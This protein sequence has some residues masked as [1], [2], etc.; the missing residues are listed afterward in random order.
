[1]AS[2]SG[3]PTPAGP[4][5]RWLVR[6]G[7]LLLTALQVYL[8][9]RLRPLLMRLCAELPFGG[10]SAHLEEPWAWILLAASVGFAALAFLRGPP[11]GWAIMGL[12]VLFIATLAMLRTWPAFFDVDHDQGIAC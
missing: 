2:E 6:G 9:F 5:E 7:A 4:I 8:T 11:K 3:I 12:V 10:C 1:M